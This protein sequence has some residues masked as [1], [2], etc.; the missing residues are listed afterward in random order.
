M[1]LQVTVQKIYHS[2]DVHNKN[3]GNA[4]AYTGLLLGIEGTSWQFAVVSW[5]KKTINT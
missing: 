5:Q 3:A 1:C 2:D 4:I